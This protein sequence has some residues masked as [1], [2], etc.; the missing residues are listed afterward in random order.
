MAICDSNRRTQEAKVAEA[1]T[2][3]EYFS[4]VIPNKVGEG[5]HILSAFKEAGVNFV[6]LW[7]YPLNKKL[8][9]ADVIPAE[10]ALFKKVAKKLGIEIEGKTACFLS[11]GEDR[12]GAVAEPLA[13]LAA[14]GISVRAVAAVCAGEGRFGALIQLDPDDVKKAAKALAK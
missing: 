14:A 3:T 7:V 2:K 10:P 6:G 9:K 5:A 11:S 8:A 12:I 13:K 4:I 1:I